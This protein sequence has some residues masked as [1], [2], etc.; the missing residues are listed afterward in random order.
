MGRQGEAS[1]DACTHWVAQVG[2]EVNGG[3]APRCAWGGWGTVWG[4]DWVCL[5]LPYTQRLVPMCPESEICL[6]FE[7][8]RTSWV[9][10]RILGCGQPC[11]WDISWGQSIRWGSVCGSVHVC[12]HAAHM[13]M[14]SVESDH[15]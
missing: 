9:P 4:W 5:S 10:G 3:F 15:E 14:C 12:L 8:W 7:G 13:C 6:M 2:S 1:L 11:S